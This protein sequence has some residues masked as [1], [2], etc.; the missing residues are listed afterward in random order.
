MELAKQGTAGNGTINENK[1]H[2]GLNIPNL[3][4]AVTILTHA[5][6]GL[7]PQRKLNELKE[8]RTLK[9][10][11]LGVKFQ[12]LLP[13]NT[14]DLKFFTNTIRTSFDKWFNAS[15]S[16]LTVYNIKKF[17]LVNKV[18]TSVDNDLFIY[19]QERKP[20]TLV[21]VTDPCQKQQAA[22]PD[23]P[24]RKGIQSYQFSSGSKS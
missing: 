22:H 18:L 10:T 19:L 14:K 23:Q 16:E 20:R 7:R 4:S 2:I 24:I 3:A 1:S 13:E 8:Y 11:L 6:E 17:I 5:Y 21:V 12:D 9:E 15:G